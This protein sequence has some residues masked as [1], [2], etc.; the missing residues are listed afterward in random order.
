MRTLSKQARLWGLVLAV[1]A[2]GGGGGSNDPGGTGPTPSIQVAVTPGTLSV[3]Q[4]ASG[5]VTV[6]VS[7]GGGF[8]GAVSL[9]VDGLPTG[10]TASAAPSPLTAG[11]TSAVVTVAVA[12]AVAPNA[13]VATI[14]A[15]ATGVGEAT[16]TYALTVSAPPAYALSATPTALTLTQ[17][18]SGATAIGVTR[19]NFTGGV[20]LVLDN[21]P[22]GITGVF[23]PN[24]ATG[25]N[26]QLT[27]SVAG[28]VAPGNY[29]LTAKGS[30]TG[31][32]DKTTAV[33]LNVTPAPSVTLATNPAVL[34]IAQGASGQSALTVTRTNYS[35]DI[36]PSASGQPSGMVVTFSPNPITGT[37][38][39]VTVAV[40]SSVPLGQY[41]ITVTGAA[42]AAGSPTTT[43]QVNIVASVAPPLIAFLRYTGAPASSPASGE[44]WKMDPTGANQVRLTN[45]ATFD[46]M[47][48]LSP[49]RQKIAFTTARAGSLDVYVMNVDGSSPAP[50][51]NTAAAELSPRWAPSG[52][53]I[54]YQLLTA[55]DCY[56]IHKVDPNGAN[57]AAAVIGNAC[58][59]QPTWSADGLYL[60][61]AD[62][63]SPQ[64][65][66]SIY[67]QTATGARLLV[68]PIAPL[69]PTSSMEPA[70]SPNGSKIVF[71]GFRSPVNGGHG[72]QI[73]VLDAAT[74]AN[75]IELTTTGNNFTPAW[76][77]DGTKI[78]F[79]RYDG[80]QYDL[81]IMDANGQNQVNLTNTPG[82]NETSPSWR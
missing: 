71:S 82:S 45:D 29:A 8:A 62:G 4:G 63:P 81:W 6:T 52:V 79:S 23:A 68:D 80:V 43:L 57:N 76:S 38:S 42:G 41:A 33:T 55:L 9:T 2:C 46:G 25:D 10:V 47:P 54:A 49:D 56:D 59:E 72:A 74:G 48:D 20:S 61:W 69:P 27:I 24:P 36:T 37:T 64:G 32:G 12:A 30:A 31:P 21:P 17:G 70:W 34:S 78:V 11:T 44:I 13:Y 60:A 39:V 53:R 3:Q 40:A 14:H 7:R 18:A 67:R 66:R 73:W 16:T 65:V 1:S 50:V 35:G 51:V 19:T 22:A 58:S 15:T 5:T 77:P 26:A 75:M 28:T